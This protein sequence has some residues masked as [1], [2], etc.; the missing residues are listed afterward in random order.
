[1]RAAIASLGFVVALGIAGGAR[2]LRVPTLA[3]GGLLA[4]FERGRVRFDTGARDVDLALVGFGR[5]NAL[6][7]VPAASPE[8]QGA[9]VH[10]RR[11]S[12]DEWYRSDARGIEQGFT[13]SAKP[14]GEGD[15]VLDLHV[16]SEGG[17]TPKTRGDGLRLDVGGQD[18]GIHDLSVVDADG[19]ALVAKMEPRDHGFAISFD[20]RDAKY[21][22]VVDPSYL[23]ETP[24]LLSGA[25]TLDSG[26]TYGPLASGIGGSYVFLGVVCGGNHSAIYVLNR[27]S[28]SSFTEIAR[29]EPPAPDNVPG[30][31]FGSSID[32]G[33]GD[34]GVLVGAPGINAAF[35]LNP[36]TVLKKFTAPGGEGSFGYAVSYYNAGGAY[37]DAVIYSNAPTPKLWTYHY[38]GTTWNN[39]GSFTVG[40][41][42]SQVT[43]SFRVRYGH[44]VG[45][46]GGTGA[47]AKIDTYKWDGSSAFVLD[48]TLGTTSSSFNPILA[49]NYT[50]LVGPQVWTYGTGWTLEATLAPTSTPTQWGFVS[51]TATA[52]SGTNLDVFQR[53]G[54]TWAKTSYPV[55]TGTTA[56]FPS[57]ATLFAEVVSNAPKSVVVTPTKANGTACAATKECTSGFCV[58]GVCCD[59]ACTGICEACTTAKKGGGTDGTCG[60]A[61]MA[62]TGRGG[63]PKGPDAICGPD[64][65]CDGAGA[66]RGPTAKGVS[67]GASSCTS[68]TVTGKTCDGAGACGSAPAD[69]APYVCKDSL[70]CFGACTDD[71]ACAAPNVCLHV[72][73][74]G[75]CGPK[76]AKGKTTTDAKLCASGFAADGVCCDEACTGTCSAC[77]ASKTGG[78]DGTCAPITNGK[79]PDSECTSACQ[80]AALLPA[81]TCDGAGACT[82]VPKTSCAPYGCENGACKTKCF[83]DSDCS[84]A[85]CESGTCKTKS[86]SGGVTGGFVKCSAPSDCA[87]GF[88]VEGVCCDSACDSPCRSCA[89]PNSPGRCSLAPSGTDPRKQCSGDQSCHQTCNGSG[90]CVVVR[91][92]DQCAPAKCTDGS[93]GVGPAVC[94]A[95]DAACPTE[96][97]VP[98]D[99]GPFACSEAL[100]ACFTQC[101]ASTD[102]AA[103]FVCDTASARC[104]AAP[105]EE[106]GGGCVLSPRRQLSSFFAGA[107]ALA[108]AAVV[109]RRVTRRGGRGS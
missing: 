67:C 92:G 8:W 101:V 50:T 32:G 107:F 41:S 26:C 46:S 45:L 36:L 7:S 93:H 68:G 77:I 97:A 98:F 24:L 64:G 90:A 56:V 74:G 53:T 71:S 55:S 13:L 108:F 105:P 33:D 104:V 94:P 100:G 80:G 82:V 2:E 21:P 1:M 9:T 28:S 83:D 19:R 103:G 72:E 89:L 10:L 34:S 63:C 35:L 73:T 69:C 106:D 27:A 3:A 17:R 43:T 54:S 39:A 70:G 51:N 40:K 11:G 44:I 61:P 58:D 47:G 12:L 81:G 25:G 91:A 49:F 85:I 38:A 20:D 99:C 76:L 16:A 14:A 59:L 30:S 65:L 57:N 60:P 42:G 6:A 95:L 52:L 29:V 5:T 66:C 75:A 87:S 109:R 102:C 79:D 37:S 31:A 4:H 22:V 88:C 62:S 23:V 18:L 84:G 86:G 78:E 48:S 96:T 15:V